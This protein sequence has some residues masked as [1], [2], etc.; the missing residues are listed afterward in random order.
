MSTYTRK[1]VYDS[2]SRKNALM[3]SSVFATFYS[4][5]ARQ[6]EGPHA[7]QSVLYICASSIGYKS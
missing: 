4:H 7:I 5:V 3:N 6:A 1:V 2:E